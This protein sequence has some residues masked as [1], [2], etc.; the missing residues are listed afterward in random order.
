MMSISQAFK[1]ITNRC[2]ARLILRSFATAQVNIKEHINV[3]TIGDEFHGKTTLTK[4]ILNTLNNNQHLHETNEDFNVLNKDKLSQIGTSGN[5][6]TINYEF[7]T[8]KRHYLL[9]DNTGNKDHV[10]NMIVGS[11]QLEC[12]ILV[13]SAIDGISYMAKQH[14][15]ILH[16]LQCPNIIV[17]FNK[18]DDEN[19]DPELQELIQMEVEETLQ[20]YN[21][22]SYS[23]TYAL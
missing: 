12:T 4:A 13:I 20:K 3:G 16:H 11:S 21:F 14:L 5:N 8:V 15:L 18:I 17:Y 6:R 9:A 23:N 19:F 22:D 10:T 2:S 1:R 7:E